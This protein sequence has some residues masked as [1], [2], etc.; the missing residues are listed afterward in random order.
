MNM[1]FMASSIDAISHFIPVGVMVQVILHIIVGIMPP[2]IGIIPLIIGIIAIMPFIIGIGIIP[3]II[4]MFIGIAAF[5]VGS[6]LLS[7]LGSWLCG[8]DTTPAR[9]INRRRARPGILLR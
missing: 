5:M 9:P 7:K 2:I 6:V 4:G 3:L 8:R 1:S